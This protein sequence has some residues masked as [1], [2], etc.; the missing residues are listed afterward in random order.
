MNAIGKMKKTGMTYA[1]SAAEDRPDGCKRCEMGND[2][3]ASLDRDLPLQVDRIAGALLP[4]GAEV[5]PKQRRR[6][7][8]Q[9]VPARVDLRRQ[10]MPLRI[11]LGRSELGVMIEMPAGELARGD[12]ARHRVEPPE[13]ALER[14]TPPLEHRVMHHFVQQHREV[15]DGEALDEGE[16]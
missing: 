2:R 14:R 12:A 15:E 4:R 6:A 3:Y 1:R 5:D 8:Q 10:V 9:F 11:V 7:V 16:R 13:R